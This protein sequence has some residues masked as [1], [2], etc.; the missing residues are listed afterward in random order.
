ML[1]INE[2][3]LIKLHSK[4]MGDKD[5]AEI[6]DCTVGTISKYRAI[7]NLPKND[8]EKLPW[9]FEKVT[10]DIIQS[11]YIEGF[12]DITI[13]KRMRRYN[14]IKINLSH[15]KHWRKIK[16]LPEA[17]NK[18]PENM[19]LKGEDSLYCDTNFLESYMG[20]KLDNKECK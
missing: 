4:G 8:T 19:D 1:K 5:L 20:R 9:Y 2:E 6:F 12:N 16:K 14:D 7:Y 11:Y 3:E 17:N 15:I 13:V 10:S 18:K